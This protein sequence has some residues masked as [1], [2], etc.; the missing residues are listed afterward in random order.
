MSQLE[1]LQELIKAVLDPSNID[2]T[3]E[4]LTAITNDPT[5]AALFFQ[6][7]NLTADPRI[8]H[9]SIIFAYQVVNKFWKR[10]DAESQQDIKNFIMQALSNDVFPGDVES[11]SQLVEVVYNEGEGKWPELIQFLLENAYA[12]PIIA[13]ACFTK[14][15]HSLHSGFF[16]L[17][18]EQLPQ[19]INNYINHE[20]I[21]VK[22]GGLAL[23]CFFLAQID[24]DEE[25]TADTPDL[26]T[27]SPE[28]YQIIANLE[29]NSLTLSDTHFSQLWSLIGDIAGS[30]K[31]KQNF[32]T[33]LITIGYNFAEN[34]E[35][36]AERRNIILTAISNGIAVLSQAELGSILTVAIDI[37]ACS[38]VEDESL[39]VD[40]L[41]L[42]ETIL[43]SQSHSE[44]YPLLIQQVMAALQSESVQHQAAA[45]LVLRVILTTT[46]EFALKD[47]QPI[48]EVINAAL[49]KEDEPIL[50][51]A[52]CFVLEVFNETFSSM[53]VYIP[54]LL[55]KLLPLLVSESS[56]VKSVAY[57]AALVL[58]ERLDCKVP[59][60][61]EQAVELYGHV[62]EDDITG[63][64][65]LVAYAIDVAPEFPDEDTVKV[66]NLLREVVSSE[67]ANTIAPATLMATALIKKDGEI[68]NDVLEIINPVLKA[69]LGFESSDVVCL[70]MSFILSVVRTFQGEEM[71]CVLPHLEFVVNVLKNEQCDH[72]MRSTALDLLCNVFHYSQSEEV[73]NLVAPHVLEALHVFLKGEVTDF[74]IPAVEGIRVLA[75]DFDEATRLDFYDNLIQS[76]ESDVTT[77]FVPKA[78]YAAA[79]L[80]MKSNENKEHYI[81]TGTE[82]L[83]NIISG[84]IDLLG[85]LPLIETDTTMNLF[86][87]VCQ[88]ITALVRSSAPISDDVTAFL[89]EWMKRD[90]EIDK[91]KAI[92]A[93][94]DIVQSSEISPELQSQIVNVV[95]AE[96]DDAEDPA[97]QE[98]IVH[99]FNIFVIQNQ[100]F[101]TPVIGVI[102][103][104]RQ[105]WTV[106]E[107][108][109]SGYGDLLLNLS[110]L[111][112]ILA[113]LNP[114]FPDDILISVLSVFP[115][116]DEEVTAALCQN[117]GSLLGSRQSLSPQLL[118]AI[119]LGFG[120]LFAYDNKHLSRMGIE[121]ELF[122][123]VR[124]MFKH[125]LSLDPQAV[126][127]IR[128]NCSS[129][130]TKLNR[131]NK[132]MQ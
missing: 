11:V 4:Q 109:R 120:R 78:L 44:T 100:E 129:T 102:E 110:G 1:N 30:Q 28:I 66:L 90:S 56:E 101:V 81:T 48:M 88:L 8:R 23:F 38:I 17:A 57:K 117:I 119:A 7:Y 91:C 32:L 68:L 82:L 50:Q 41:A 123:E 24:A 105:W 130:K 9:G 2:Q 72:R 76:V 116:E 5:S 131:I 124:G 127:I 93:L 13:S 59:G 60:L 64:F 35:I 16:E 118:R 106:A 83:K 22:I 55:Q 108:N 12:K 99:I 37:A 111:F 49:E 89:L 71:E 98:N 52:A 47:S 69:C 14:I 33:E 46:P 128:Q 103:K 77:T 20:D 94:S 92:G 43:N 31:C 96:I 74:A 19:L 122:D 73:T 86:P 58:C 40:Q 121:G 15:S 95:A 42:F 114:E 3:T 26:I 126:Q 54:N 25:D 6:L 53:N 34:S 125:V 21:T 45:M 61:F 79:K 115:H 104:L 18:C 27:D 51:H 70:T 65:S 36:K 97:M 75:R 112:I 132:I 39:P 87:S 62:T 29:Q 80:L 107:Q 85:G 84:N 63:Y 67:N 10:Y 113:I